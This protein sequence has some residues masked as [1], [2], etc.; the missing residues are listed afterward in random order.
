MK[1]KT[2]VG[3]ITVIVNLFNIPLNCTLV[4]HTV[5]FST[6]QIILILCDFARLLI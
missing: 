1:K 3:F 5:T 4:S 6:F 2:A